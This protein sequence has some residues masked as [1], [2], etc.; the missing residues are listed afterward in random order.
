MGACQIRRSIVGARLG[1]P[2]LGIIVVSLVLTGAWLVT[3]HYLATPH[4][5]T[6]S[7]FPGP[8]ASGQLLRKEKT[9]TI[10]LSF[11]NQET[12]LPPIFSIRWAG[13]WYTPDE[14]R[15]TFQTR[16][17]SLVRVYL[18]AV[19]VLLHETDATQ[20]ASATVTITP[21]AHQ[22]VVDYEH[23]SNDPYLSFRWA[24]ENASPRPLSTRNLFTRRLDRAGYDESRAVSWLG[25]L[26][27]SGWLIS[28]L[29]V[30]AP[31]LGRR[32]RDIQRVEL[33]WRARRLAFPALLGP[34]QVFLFGAHMIYLGNVREF[35]VPFW[36]L[37]VHW[38]P[39]VALAVAIAAPGLAGDRRWFHRY[40]VALF[41]FG[42]L[43]WLQGGLLL[44]SY[45][46][47]DGQALDW[48][49]HAWRAPYEI[50]LWVVI[51]IAMIA[52][53]RTVF[54]VAPFASQLLIALQIVVLLG[55]AAR[56]RP[57]ST[58]TPVHRPEFLFELSRTQNVIHLVLDGFQSDVF[59]EIIENVRPELASSLSGFVFFAD[60]AG[61][62]RTTIASMP[63]M[64][65]GEPY[66]NQEPIESFIR[67]RSAER[68]LFTV[69]REHGFE[70]DAVS[71]IGAGLDSATNAYVIP[72]PYV[73]VEEDYNRFAAWQ[74]ADLSFF[75][76]APHFLKRWVYND[77]R[78]RLQV[79]FGKRGDDA[80]AQRRYHAAN[81]HAF[82]ADWIQRARVTRDQPVY[83]LLH[84]GIP[85]Q[86]VVLDA[87]CEFI[88]V[89][90][91]RRDLY[92]EQ[93]TCTVDLVIR[94]LDRL[95]TLGVYDNSVI[96]V[97][98]DHGTH[99]VPRDFVDDHSLPFSWDLEAIAG[100]A[101]ALLA[102]KPAEAADSL[103]ISYAPTA[104]TDIP[105]T[106]MDMLGID[107]SY[108]PG[109][110][111]LG[112][113][114][115]EPRERI[116]AWY[117]WDS[118]AWQRDYIQRLDLFSIKG[119][120]SNR[121]SWVYRGTIFEPD[122]DLDRLSSGWEWFEIDESNRRVRRI[123]RHAS[124]YA[125]P[126]ARSMILEM[127][128]DA[129]PRQSATVTILV[130]GDRLDRVTLDEPT[131]ETFELALPV[132]PDSA[133]ARIDLSVDPVDRLGARSSRFPEVMS[134]D[135]DWRR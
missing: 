116:F 11:L 53:S 128:V 83:K 20:A 101:H 47:L 13:Y 87:D 14:Q 69:L 29:L 51:P 95:R 112:L 76:H 131:W 88:G 34:L 62:F 21:G 134:R 52:A 63:A 18:D 96:V 58:S 6:R 32:L 33:L 9:T 22:L 127:K 117:P 79:R 8:G 124:F 36:R 66:R 84:V 67:H 17:N 103:R 65:T 89:N 78:W 42:L 107:E 90:P 59:H 27:L 126:R 102:V 3:G 80:T 110:S 57:E 119:S 41:G 19:P 43:L 26:V 30:M 125:P 4:G 7:I 122:T 71:I 115:D 98:S 40:V 86:P 64:L 25:W 5:L 24:P 94:F 123:G 75:R 74:L 56:V 85:H 99:L 109:R 129:A 130:N 73:D 60:H 92:L 91:L 121:G 106:V 111:A 104:I 132:L 105:A 93:A 31:A 35:S 72:Q 77:Q 38:W 68:S 46:P 118:A 28:A 133:V 61:A 45:G 135:V 54:R 70:S 12:D 15:I 37:A 81:G 49:L 97:S 44:A 48:N 82:L 108:F 120:I 55:S 100:I 1:I 2:L 16:A 113:E 50:G 39:V 23:Q 10:E 114:T